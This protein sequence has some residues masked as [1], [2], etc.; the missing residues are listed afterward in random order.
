VHAFLEAATH[1]TSQSP[2][3]DV[4]ERVERLSPAAE[5]STQLAPG[6]VGSE[7]SAV[8]AT[9]SHSAPGAKHETELV[10]GRVEVPPAPFGPPPRVAPPRVTPLAP[11]RYAIQFTAKQSLHEKLRYAQDL[12]R[13]QIPDG[14]LSDVIE[15]ALDALIPALERRKFA[16]TSKPRKRASKNSQNPRHIPA[17]IKRE[18]WARDGARCTY[19]SA[20][21]HRCEATG[22]LEFDH[23]KPVSKAGESKAENLRLL[24]RA[25]N[26]FM[27]GESLGHGFMHEARER[28]RSAPGSREGSRARP[29]RSLETPTQTEHTAQAS[30]ARGPG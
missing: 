27:A 17:A 25:H 18:V 6:R 14:S 15:R 30:L 22:D 8:L 12:L 26:A 9:D 23:I 3:P 5:N 1:G 11:E 24:C 2:R 29:A 20:S 10:P 21:G 16:A 28:S 4:P 13:H 19:V 7:A